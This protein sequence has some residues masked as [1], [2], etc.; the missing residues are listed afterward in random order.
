MDFRDE[1]K[2]EVTELSSDE[3]VERIREGVMAKLAQSAQSYPETPVKKP[4][5]T[6]RIAMIGGSIAACL[7]IGFTAIAVSNTRLGE[8]LFGT[9]MA[10]NQVGAA[11]MTGG[12][13][14]N[15]GSIAAEGINGMGGYD[16]T[17][18]AP[19]GG[20]A[21]DFDSDGGS[22]GSDPTNSGPQ[23]VPPSANGD[24]LGESGSS[25]PDAE[26]D[27][28]KY[29]VLITFEGDGFTLT[30]SMNGRVARF[31]P[32]ESDDIAGTYFSPDELH[33]D[34]LVYTAEGEEYIVEEVPGYVIL[35]NDELMILGR[36][37]IVE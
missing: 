9:D 7:V 20:S 2:K 25:Y 18:Q 26:Q 11:G 19:S 23:S 24:A 16:N 30:E 14:Q 33:S 36:Y 22:T 37:E 27:N 10:P 17:N 6:K 3:T 13:P 4:L 28:S 32:T 15:S 21:G 8:K 5:P 1:Y 35:L 12:S 29:F 31:S 34:V